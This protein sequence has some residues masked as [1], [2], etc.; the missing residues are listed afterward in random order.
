MNPH[1]ERVSV[2]ISYIDRNGEQVWCGFD[3]IFNPFTPP[4]VTEIAERVADAI[5]RTMADL[6]PVG[7]A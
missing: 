5:V 3:R 1:I 4:P 2:K 7:E 6:M